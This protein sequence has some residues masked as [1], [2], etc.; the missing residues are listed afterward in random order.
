[1]AVKAHRVGVQ[2]TCPRFDRRCF[3]ARVEAEPEFDFDVEPLDNG[4]YDSSPFV[5]GWS[6]ILF[7]QAFASHVCR[8]HLHARGAQRGRTADF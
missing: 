6:V 2:P 1:M 8:A 7:P 5:A 4:H 3:A